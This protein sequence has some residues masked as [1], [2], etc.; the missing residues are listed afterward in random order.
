MSVPTI[1]PIWL[2]TDPNGDL[3]DIIPLTADNA[4]PG[5]FPG[6]VGVEGENS[7]TDAYHPTDLPVS[8]AADNQGRNIDYELYGEHGEVNRNAYSIYGPVEP[9]LVEDFQLYGEVGK[10]PRAPEWAFG[11]VGAYDHA[12]YTAMQVMQQMSPEAYTEASLMSLL[13]EGI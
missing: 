11:P 13:T 7:F 10:F 1:D 4:Y 6:Y 2:E 12:G 5:F 8:N 9:N 3:S